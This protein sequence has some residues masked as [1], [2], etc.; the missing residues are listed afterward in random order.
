MSRPIIGIGVFLGG[1]KGPESK[2]VLQHIVTPHIVK[3]L[4]TDKQALV[5]PTRKKRLK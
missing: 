1:P 4:P 2:T 3:V 5:I